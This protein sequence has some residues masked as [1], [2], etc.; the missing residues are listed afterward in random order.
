MKGAADFYFHA[1]D[2]EYIPKLNR[3]NYE[4]ETAQLIKLFPKNARVLQ[5]GSMDGRRALRLLH[6]R[7]DL[8]YTGLDI[9]KPFI[10]QARK[11]AAQAGVAAEYV[12]GDIT[13]P[14]E[15]PKFDYVICL[16]NTLGYISEET[17]ALQGM[18]HLGEHIFI[19]V[20]GTRFTAKLAREYFDILGQS[21][22]KVSDDYFIL[23]DLTRIRRFTD[24]HVAD[25]G[26]HVRK[27]P[28]GYLCTL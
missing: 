23:A 17:P 21:V 8:R 25:W 18:E 12:L 22:R 7:P 2:L 10:I 11:N 20:F 3:E 15:L 19:S 16:N 14:P 5:V 9:E 1:D 24:K 6:L 26:G 4:Y 13:A 28:L 27:S